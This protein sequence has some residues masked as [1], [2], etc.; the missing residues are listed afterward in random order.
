MVHE[1]T[2]A[3]SQFMSNDRV[4][5]SCLGTCP[6][7]TSWKPHTLTLTLSRPTGER[8]TQIERWWTARTIPL[9]IQRLGGSEDRLT[10]LPLYRM[11]EGRGKGRF[12]PHSNC[13]VAPE[14]VQQ[15]AASVQ[16]T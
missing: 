14:Q 10:I 7:S 13:F 3:H 15:S 9:Q 11:G 6:Q 2:I 1:R 4:G 16:K 12:R 8:E 5:K